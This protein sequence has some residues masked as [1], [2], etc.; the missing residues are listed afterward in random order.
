MFLFFSTFRANSMFLFFSTFRA[1]STILFDFVL[2]AT[3][4]ANFV[5]LCY[6]GLSCKFG[7]FVLF[8]TFVQILSG[9]GCVQHARNVHYLR[10]FRVACYSTFLECSW[11]PSRNPSFR[12]FVGTMLYSGSFQQMISFFQK[13]CW[14]DA[15]QSPLFQGWPTMCLQKTSLRNTFWK[16]FSGSFFQK[17]CWNDALQSPLFQGWPTMCLQKT[18]LRNTF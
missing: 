7:E 9:Q 2:F 13:F 5:S 11:D 4:R 3:F 16:T 10:G 12:N 15:L 6:F 18:S 17:F 1:N 8:W 14:N